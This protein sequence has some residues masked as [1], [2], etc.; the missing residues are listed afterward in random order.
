MNVSNYSAKRKKKVA[1]WC[2]SRFT[3][4]VVTTFSGESNDELLGGKLPLHCLPLLLQMHIPL[5]AGNQKGVQEE[6]GLFKVKDF[7][8]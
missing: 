6:V 1:T 7:L 8:V 2:Q 3:V 4:S 5:R